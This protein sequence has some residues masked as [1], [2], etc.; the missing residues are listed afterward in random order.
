MER[1]TAIAEAPAPAEAAP[2]RAG[3]ATIAPL[4]QHVLALQRA[5]GNRATGR[6]LAQRPH[7]ARAP[8]DAVPAAQRTR[9][10]E[11][12][13]QLATIDVTAI[14]SVPGA[15]GA[16]VH[17]T[18]TPAPAYSAGIP[19]TLQPVLMS[20]LGHLLGGAL[21]QNSTSAVLLDLTPYG[22]S[23]RVYRFTHVVSGDPPQP[24]YFIEEIGAEAAAPQAPTDATAAF[25]SGH[26]DAHSFTAPAGDREFEAVI[27]AAVQ[28][29]PD[30]LLT[31]IDGVSFLRSTTDP[32][33]AATGGR[34]DHQAHTV[35]IFDP[36]MTQTTARFG[37]RG[38]T[39]GAVGPRLRVILH[40]LGHA[41]D[42]AS[43]RRA[44]RTRETAREAV[45]T[46]FAQY[47]G[48]DGAYSFPGNLQGE[49]DRMSAAATAA[50]TA[51]TGTRSASGHSFDGGDS[52]A[53][54]TDFTRAV[55]A[56]GSVTPTAYAESQRT[57]DHHLRETYAET[58]AM[59]IT[60]PQT[61]RAIRP[62]VYAHFA[63]LGAPRRRR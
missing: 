8:L 63:G 46:R 58:F 23:S 50:D 54:A 55:A 45:E 60:E 52:A 2:D 47:R 1:T 25:P 15:E 31:M 39:G 26:F 34:Y 28:M 10:R 38:A 41:I 24:T 53:T 44:W 18:V 7:V 48:A 59:F 5:A 42:E 22:G 19:A 36:G 51:Y 6:A 21:P 57:A 16:R 20:V 56:D 27:R 30:A 13:D 9:L 17:G 14:H 40:E 3:P 12:T 61:L 32:H 33:D 37:D 62:S 4:P 29:V 43:L 11:V 35:T 49:F